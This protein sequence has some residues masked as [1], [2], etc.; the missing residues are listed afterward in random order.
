MERD[1]QFNEMMRGVDAMLTMNFIN[2]G[3]EFSTLE[4]HVSA[5]YFRKKFQTKGKIRCATIQI[6]GL[7]FYELHINGVDITKGYL[8][9]YRSNHDHY[10][11]VDEYDLLPYLVNGNN[12]VALILGNGMQNAVGGYHWKFDQAPWRGAPQVSFEILLE[13]EDDAKELIVSDETVKTTPSPILFD[14]LFYGEYY[15]A[16]KEIQGWDL[17]EYD[18]G[19][20]DFAKSV[21]PPKGELRMVEAE[22]IV[23]KRELNPVSIIEYKGGY[24]YDFGENTAGICRLAIEHTSC[25]QKILLQHFETMDD[26]KPHFDGIRFGYHGCED[27]FQED[28]YYCAG[29]EKEVHVP[30]FTYHGFRYVYVTG[31]QAEQATPTLLTYLEFYSDIH[32]IGSFECSDEMANKIQEITLRSDYSNFHYFPTDC[33]HREK[34]GWTADAA[35]SAEQMLLNTTPEKSYREW[36]RNVYKALTPE[37]KLPGFVPTANGGYAWGNGPAWDNVLVYVPYYTYKYRGDREI[38]EECAGPLM[39]YLN[40]LSGRLREDNLAEFGLGD[41]C[42]AG[43]IGS[44]FDTPLVVTDSIMSIDIARKAEFIYKVLGMAVQQ[45]YA[46]A[47]GD[48]I[49]SVFCEKLIDK[50]TCIVEGDTQTAQ[51]MAIYYGMFSGEA[52]KKAFAH[53]LKQIERA[54]GHMATGVLGG[55][56]IFRVLAEN[57]ESDLAYHMITR[58]DFP[59]YGN[60]VA[61]GSTTLWEHFLPEG[62]RILSR[63]HQFW[64]DVSAWFYYYPGGLRFNPSGKD[65]RHVDIEPCFIE[66]LDY[67]KVSH[68]SPDGEI[69]ISWHR[70]KGGVSLHVTAP[71][72]FYGS[73]RLP[74]GY[75]YEDNSSV[76]HL[77]SGVYRIKKFK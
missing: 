27:L 24:I 26:G 31:I 40:Y 54:N 63:N 50:N 61:R 59:S 8:A 33:P 75:A 22:P 77:K 74:D 2:A 57:G 36:M 16:R 12:V 18:D 42:Q 66:A 19:A 6:C 38:L 35:L 55:R 68:H 47:L 11:Y 4:H 34:A 65:I 25:G 53:L 43:R 71:E 13:Y 9:P 73:I 32:G 69:K 44:D 20:W 67:V 52:K 76:S 45:K 3:N 62:A 10:I 39:R 28:I 41:W 48:K 29:R 46:K 60:W 21:I 49:Q 14:D 15:D 70:E 64:G 1:S 58:P 30:R 37:G 5:P 56:V 23:L 7:G 17:V 72:V 51:A